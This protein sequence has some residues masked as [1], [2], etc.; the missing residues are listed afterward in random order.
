MFCP[1]CGNAIENG[2][3]FCPVCGARV[4]QLSTAE[5]KTESKPVTGIIAKKAIVFF[6]IAALILTF[7]SVTVISIY[8]LAIMGHNILKFYLQN[9]T[10]LISL[11][12][13]PVLAGLFV[14][15]CALLDK[16]TPVLT[17]IPRILFFVISL[18]LIFVRAVFLRYTFNVLEEVFYYLF[19]LCFIIF[20]MLSVAGKLGSGYAG[21]ILP[22]IFGGLIC[23]ME[24]IYC[25][26]YV[27][28]IFKLSGPY[29][30]L[31]WIGNII[32]SI[33]TTVTI[34]TMVLIVFHVYASKANRQRA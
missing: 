32:G 22:T 7:L 6:S 5:V 8:Y 12:Y 13:P 20:Y 27:V 21:K 17:G 15:F 16:K 1:S 18:I 10:Q 34:F 28:L 3:S 30:F 14:L 23:I 2:I 31:L 4:P 9:F 33:A 11:I 24:F 29:L 19:T 26:E 25:I